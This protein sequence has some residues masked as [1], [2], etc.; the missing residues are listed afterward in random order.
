MEGFINDESGLL[1]LRVNVNPYKT[2][3]IIDGDALTLE[4]YIVL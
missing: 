1:Y 2:A 4:T 3:H